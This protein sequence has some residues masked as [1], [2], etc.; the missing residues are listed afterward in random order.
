MGEPTLL[1]PL[2]ATINMCILYK[3]GLSVD[4]SLHMRLFTSQLVT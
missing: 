2:Y 1:L 4:A 3:K